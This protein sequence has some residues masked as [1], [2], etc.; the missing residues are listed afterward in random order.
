MSIST[1]AACT[2]SKTEVPQQV[3]RYSC[4]LRGQHSC[5][6][7][8]FEARAVVTLFGAVTHVRATS[9]FVYVMSCPGPERSDAKLEPG[10][11]QAG[12]ADTRKLGE[13]ITVKGYRAKAEPF[14][15]RGPQDG[16]AGSQTAD[17]GGR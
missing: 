6:I 12:H 9:R 13:V 15:G 1:V 7:L 14:V 8:W 4:S 3:V 17:I 5:I 10:T 11:R 2:D 16:D